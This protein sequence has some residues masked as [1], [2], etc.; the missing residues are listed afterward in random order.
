VLEGAGECTTPN[1]GAKRAVQSAPE[2]TIGADSLVRSKPVGVPA[3][4]IADAIKAL[5]ASDVSRPRGSILNGPRGS[6][7]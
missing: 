1:F 5:A 3:V 2:C 4:R 7:T 6:S